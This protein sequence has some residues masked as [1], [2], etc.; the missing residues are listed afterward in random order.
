LY[1][2]FLNVYFIMLALYCKTKVG[3]FFHTWE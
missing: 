2:F 3:Q 1:F